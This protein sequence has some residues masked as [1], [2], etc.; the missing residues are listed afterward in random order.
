M[1]YFDA[2]THV[3]FPQYDADRAE[4]VRAVEK[5]DI[6][7]LVVGCDLESSKRAVEF[8][9]DKEHFYA[10][11]GLHPNHE[12]DEWFEAKNYLPFFENK[13]VVAVGECGLDYFRPK[14]IDD[15]LKQKQKNLFQDHIDLAVE[16]GRPLI[17]HARPSKGT[18]DAYED[19]LELL[20]NAKKDHPELRGDFHFFVGDVDVARKI[21]ELDFTMSFTAVLTFTREYDEVVRFIPQTHILTETDAPYVAPASRRG[22]RND[23]LA[24]IDVL[25]A[26]ASIRG[27][28]SEELRKAVLSNASSLFRLGL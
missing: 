23:S 11:V 17:I 12:E 14:S 7:G 4:V 8:V 25:S 6:G 22:E 21:L 2:H 15:E 20:T 27:E 9:S 24:V 26:M 28:D 3:Q 1:K 19:A 5:A 10:S 18:V 16:S 13:K